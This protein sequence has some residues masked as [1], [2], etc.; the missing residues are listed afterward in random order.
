M[1]S[2]TLV[3]IVFFGLEK[4][5]LPSKNYAVSSMVIVRWVGQNTR[6][7][8]EY[9]GGFDVDWGEILAIRMSLLRLTDI[10]A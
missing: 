10:C 2:N 7:F 4:A 3:A 6:L 9:G 8:C 1:R 5:T